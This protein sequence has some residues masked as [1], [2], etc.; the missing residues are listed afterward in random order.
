[1]S[2]YSILRREGGDLDASIGQ[3]RGSE[4]LPNSLAHLVAGPGVEA[5]RRKMRR[6]HVRASGART[7]GCRLYGRLVVE[8]NV[9][10]GT[11][12]VIEIYV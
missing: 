1:M 3:L 9:I 10:G 6:G 5:G 11:E 12:G 4:G 2:V 8:C 7:R